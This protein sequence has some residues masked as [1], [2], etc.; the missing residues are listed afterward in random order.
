MFRQCLEEEQRPY[1]HGDKSEKVYS[2]KTDGWYIIRTMPRSFQTPPIA[3]ILN[4]NV[5]RSCRLT[6]IALLAFS[7]SQFPVYKLPYLPDGPQDILSIGG[8]VDTATWRPLVSMPLILNS[9]NGNSLRT[10]RREVT[11]I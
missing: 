9:P 6:C 4:H 10:R 7:S 11:G 1:V 8:L 2:R 3:I 5:N